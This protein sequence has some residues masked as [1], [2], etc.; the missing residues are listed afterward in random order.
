MSTVSIMALFVFMYVMF[1][2]VFMLL[3]ACMI[4]VMLMIFIFIMIMRY[5]SI[6]MLG[7]RVIVFLSVI[8]GLG[9]G[10]IRGIAIVRCRALVSATC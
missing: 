1:F 5:W 10:S 9:R 3:V 7:W 2:I 4:V 8:S 6:V